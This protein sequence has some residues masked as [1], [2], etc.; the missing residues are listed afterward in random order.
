MQLK[1]QGK[2]AQIEAKSSEE[3]TLNGRKGIS[4]EFYSQTELLLENCW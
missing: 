4:A 2:A 1:E 3:R